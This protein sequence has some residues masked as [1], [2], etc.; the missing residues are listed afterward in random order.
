MK[1]Y[2]EKKIIELP[3]A[4]LETMVHTIKERYLAH[5]EAELLA[6]SEGKNTSNKRAYKEAKSFL[7]EHTLHRWIMEQNKSKRLSAEF[8]V[9]MD[10]IIRNQRCRRIQ[11][12][13]RQ[14]G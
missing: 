10:A 8:K 13:Q 3:H 2:L 11:L 9:G 4:S 5:S 1:D 14:R 12:T 6:T 7:A